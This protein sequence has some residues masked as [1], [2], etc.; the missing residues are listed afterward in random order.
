M[1]HASD[2]IFIYHQVSLA[3]VESIKA[4]LTLDI[5]AALSGISIHSIHTDDGVFSSKHHMTHLAGKG[6]TIT[7][8][9]SGAANQNAIAVRAI[10]TVVYMARTI[11]IH[12]SSR[13]PENTIT[14]DLWPMAMDYTAWIYNHLSK[15]DTGLSLDEIWTKS[16]FTSTGDI[17]SRCHTWVAPTYV[18]EPKLQKSGIKIPKWA[19][20]SRR[21]GFYGLQS[22]SF[23]SSSS[24]A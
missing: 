1:D 7:F 8:C 6:Q 2:C 23:N 16:R 3:A 12:A 20:R 17:L 19:P 15:S 11:L 4:K 9:G 5:D 10:N 14:L 24:C 13:S 18:L 21:G 22:T